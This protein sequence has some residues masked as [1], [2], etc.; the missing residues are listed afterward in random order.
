MGEAFSNPSFLFVSGLVR[1]VSLGDRP[2][3]APPLT[4]DVFVDGGCR[5]KTGAAIQFNGVARARH[6]SAEEGSRAS[7]DRAGGEAV[8]IHSAN[9]LVGWLGRHQ[10]FSI[11]GLSLGRSARWGGR[12][13]DET[14]GLGLEA[15]RVA[16][17]LILF[18]AHGRETIRQGPGPSLRGHD[19]A[20]NGSVVQRTWRSLA[21]RSLR[22]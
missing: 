7:A 20:R 16:S 17:E 11:L 9:W 1:K 14:K 2:C 13:W 3:L 15:L 22:G 18:S 6:P 19:G 10:A 21:I 5:P 8:S 12:A 4:A